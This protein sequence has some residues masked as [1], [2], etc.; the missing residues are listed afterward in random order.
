VPNWTVTAASRGVAEV[1]RKADAGE[2]LSLTEVAFADAREEIS[3]EEFA[4]LVGRGPSAEDAP[5]AVE[6]DR[7]QS[8]VTDF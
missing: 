1:R 2:P 3:D 7:I 4:S 5:T 6:D 8:K